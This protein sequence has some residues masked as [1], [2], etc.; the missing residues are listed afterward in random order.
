MEKIEGEIDKIIFHNNSN[1]FTVAKLVDGTYV[2]GSIVNLQKGEFIS[3]VGKWQSHKIYG[4]QFLIDSYTTKLPTDTI[5]IQRYLE[6][7][8]VK[9]IGPVYAKNIVSKFKENTLEVID[10]NPHLLLQVEGIGKKRI[11]KIKFFWDKQRAIREV[12]IFLRSFNISISFSQKIYKKYKEESIYKIKENPYRIAK[13]IFGIG[14]KN[15]DNVAQKMGF[16]KTSKKRIKAGIEYAFLELSNLGHTCIEENRLINKTQTILDIQP[17]LI[18]KVLKE[19]IEEEDL[20]LEKKDKKNFLWYRSFYFSEKKIIKNLIRL[21]N[22]KSLIRKIDEEKAIAWVEKLQKIKL[23]ENQIEAVKKAV[24]SK[25][26]IITG[27]P[28]TGKS[29]I[30]KSIINILEKL[31]K[32]IILAAPTGRAAKRLQEITKKKAFTIHSLLEMNFLDGSF[33]KNKNNPIDSDLIIIDEASMIDTFLMCHLL[34]AIPNNS[35]VIFIGDI[36]QLPSIGPGYVLKDMIMSKQI[37]TSRL[38]KIFRQSK[39]SKII[40]NAHKINKGIFPDISNSPFS[41]F[42]FIFEEDKYKIQKKIVDLIYIEIPKKYKISSFS[43]QVLSP[44]KKGIIG[45]E[46]LNEVIQ[47]KINPSATPFYKN[48]KCFHINDKVMQIRNNYKK[49]VYNGDIGKIIKIDEEIEILFDRRVVKYDISEIDEIV[50][51]YAVS[52]H[53]YQGSECNFIIMP[54]H[55]SHFKLLYRNLLYT[56]ITRSKKNFFLVGTK[57]AISIAIKNEEVLKRD[58]GLEFFLKKETQFI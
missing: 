48:D 38:F 24:S 3:G 22:S 33:K 32:K 54:I 58:T 44:M 34:E 41:D 15:A 46:N 11:E 18:Q 56:A 19:M 21:K 26:H 9:G 50:L 14:F 25:L 51:A 35:K 53:K 8:L 42:Q 4:K 23:E 5:G 6:S 1:N 29:T 40:T 52:V 20:I 17:S 47:N 45:T 7:G 57:K 13:E 16:E 31:T 43:I 55:E 10:K 2:V 28:G 39:N 12:M 36:D 30:T 27:G 49:N 37:G